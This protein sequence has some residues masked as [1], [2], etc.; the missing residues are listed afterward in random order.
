MPLTL[1]RALAALPLAFASLALAQQGYPSKP[2]RVFVPV[3]AASGVDIIIRKA[4]EALHPRLGQPFVVE[5]RASANMVTGTDACGKAAPDGHTICTLSSLPLAYAPFTISSLPYDAEKDFRPVTNMFF[6]LEGLM[7]KAA[8]PVNSVKELQALAVASPGKLN[9]GTLGPGSTTDVSR[10]WLEETW[11]TK[12]AGIPYKGGPLVVQALAAGEIDFARIGA[13]N[14]IPLIKAGKLK[15]L[16][17][18]GTKRSPVF[19]SVP[20]NDEVG[21]EAMPPARP[22]WGVFAP[23]ATPD[24]V[25]RRLNSE[26]VRL[27]HEPAF[28]E[29]MDTQVVEINTNTP[30]EFAAFV[31]KERELAG[32]I[33]K[34]YNIPRQ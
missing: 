10:Q 9:F 24:P 30:E 18:G 1:A 15:L 34:R 27:F 14:A 29:F 33:V 8:L 3:P 17:L 6:L 19:P 31:R 11:H 20:V 22:W 12:I 4:G 13:Y 16:A 32:Q 23:G 7:T 25:I 28:V 21:L 26:F 5:N 2:I